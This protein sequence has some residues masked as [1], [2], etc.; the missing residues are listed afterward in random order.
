[1]TASHFTG[2]ARTSALLY[3]KGVFTTVA[4]FAGSP[5]LWEKHWRRLADGAAKIGL[6]LSEHSNKTVHEALSSE[7]SSQCIIDGRARI[8]FY[9]RTEGPHWSTNEISG[10][11]IVILIAPKR[12][13]KRDL[14]L[15][16]SPFSLN[17]RS[18]LAGVKSC[19][20]LENILAMDEAK[21][22]GFHEAIRLNERG[23]ITSGCMA[24]VFWLKDGKLFT[25]A[26]S[27]GCL[28]GTTREHIIENTEFEEVVAGIDALKIA[29]AIFLTSAGLGIAAVA[30]FEGRKTDPV[31]FPVPNLWPQS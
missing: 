4:I 20:Y 29:E 31:E 30:E 3:G 1:M 25:P 15:T 19:N 27:T 13:T 14:K 23:E 7:I 10:T 9:D 18:P 5:F 16:V 6:D 17:S 22:R 28:A 12:S 21:G 8:T 24:N 26:L 2:T 11:E